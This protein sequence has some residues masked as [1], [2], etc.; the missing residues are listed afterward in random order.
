MLSYNTSQLTDKA[1]SIDIN[2]DYHNYGSTNS[3]S[4]NI[5]VKDEFNGSIDFSKLF[6]RKMPT[7]NDSLF[8]T[9]PTNNVPG[10]HDLTINLDTDNSIDEIN[11]DNNS[12]L[13]KL[14]V[15][16]STLRTY[17]DYSVN[18]ESDGK[19]K[20]INPTLNPLSEKI[21]L[22]LS[23]TKEFNSPQE[24]TKDFDTLV[25][26]VNINSLLNS[27][28]Y[29]FRGKILGAN[30]FNSEQSFYLGKKNRFLLSD[31]VSFATTEM[32]NLT[33]MNNEI[34]LDSSRT[35]ISVL[36]AVQTMVI[37]R[38]LQRMEKILFRKTHF[39]AIMFAYLKIRLINL[40]CIKDLMFRKAAQ[41]VTDYINFL[42]TLPANYLIAVAISDNGSTTNQDLKN[43]LKSFG[44][45]YADSLVF[46]S[47]WAFI[48]KKGAI[49][50]SMPEAFSRPF[51]GRVK[52]RYNYK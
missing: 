48:G 3:D 47:S 9:I 19:I 14:N 10:E 13:I 11:E 46:R 39:L 40:L 28:R 1:D 30:D 49:P 16:S 24:I 34:Q 32:S 2:I 51:L 12:I 45:I 42:D 8:V 44:S 25:T 29:Y 5:L 23:K 20:I 36:S 50:G 37:Q 18:Q 4:I 7:L 41:V 26:T 22:Q 31:S 33:Y 21:V 43:E 35:T 6:K 27:G 38:S 15:A 52:A 17:Y